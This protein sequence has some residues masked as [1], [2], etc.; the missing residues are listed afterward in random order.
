MFLV[1]S[2]CH[3]QLLNYKEKHINIIDVL[4]KAAKKS[5]RLVLSVSTVL[6]DY[7][8]MI[9]YIKN[10]RNDIFFSCGVHPIYAN[11]SNNIYTYNQ[12]NALS[13][14]KNVIA[15]GETGLDYYHTANNKKQ[16]Q[17]LFREH[18][19]VAKIV[20]KPVIVHSRNA[21]QDTIMLLQEEQA[22]KCGGILHCFNEDIAMAKSLLD[23]NFYISFSGIIT[24]R[25]SYKLHEVLQYVP[26]DRI[27]L[28]T[29]SPYL[30][31]IP[32]RGQE[33]QPAYIYDIAKCLALIKKITV[34]RLAYATTSNFFSL[35]HIK[36]DQYDL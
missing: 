3:L 4:E 21:K 5:V 29:D 13:A 10:N 9:K 8:N 7:N 33:N 1:D 28:E 12:L 25:N 26:L 32:H 17:Q 35:F 6:S 34:E 2:H 19:N 27:L 23:L 18:I 16:Q 14:N 20:K 22:A 36:R 15:I 11:S 24:F 30:T 31:P